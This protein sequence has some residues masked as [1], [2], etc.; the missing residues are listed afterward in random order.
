MARTLVEVHGLLADCLISARRK[1]E[2][3]PGP[4][5]PGYL[6]DESADAVTLW[7]H[8][9]HVVSIYAN[10]AGV[11]GIRP[12]WEAFW[13]DGM[14]RAAFLRLVARR[15]RIV[16][17]ISNGGDMDTTLLDDSVRYWEYELALSALTND[18]HAES[19]RQSGNR[20]AARRIML[21]TETDLA[22]IQAYAGV[23]HATLRRTVRDCKGVRPTYP[24][25]R[26]GARKWDA[27]PLLDLIT[28]NRPTV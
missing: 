18:G 19:A 22:V 1:Y 26:D 6:G 14:D 5:Q 16:R 8:L 4:G 15:S 7:R 28:A 25:Y 23:D 9:A 11:R 21:E 27:H 10:G 24:G 12:T 2:G 17:A 20:E 13:E 3:R